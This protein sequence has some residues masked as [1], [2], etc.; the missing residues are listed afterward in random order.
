MVANGSGRGLRLK[1][2]LHDRGGMCVRSVRV[3]AGCSNVWPSWYCG[4]AVL[5]VVAVGAG[6]RVRLRLVMG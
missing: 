3:G 2:L 1:D 6:P 4:G 5:D